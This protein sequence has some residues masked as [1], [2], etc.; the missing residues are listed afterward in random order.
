MPM[1]AVIRRRCPASKDVPPPS[2]GVLFF[3]GFRH[4][5]NTPIILE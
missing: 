2:V 4:L 5:I 3:K 1:F